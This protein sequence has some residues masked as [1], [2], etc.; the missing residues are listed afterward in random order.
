M[1]R[2][3]R[4]M[5]MIDVQATRCP[6][7]T[8]NFTGS[9]MDAGFKYDQRRRS[10]RFLIFAGLFFAGLYWLQTG[11]ADKLGQIM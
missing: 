4:C 9:D 1:K 10:L 11:G 3:P 5:T 2:C 6:S 8:T 7:C